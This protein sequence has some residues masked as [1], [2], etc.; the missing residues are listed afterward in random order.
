MRLVTLVHLRPD[1]AP[2]RIA[3]LEAVVAGLPDE[4]S[5]VRRV[6]LGKHIPG[7]VGAG[8]YTWDTLIG[9][10]DVRAVLDAPSLRALLEAGDLIERLDPVAFEPQK[11][12]IEEPDISKGL[13]RTL[14]VRLLP[15]TPPEVIAQF[16]RDILGMPEHI[17]G[18]RNWA[19]SRAD[20]SLCP[21]T[22]THV[23]EQ[24]YFD[25][26]GFDADYMMH[27]YHWGL[28]DGWFD[29][30][31]PQR[32]VD[33]AFAHCLCPAEATILGWK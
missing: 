10:G 31:C 18:I 7:Q 17:H 30:E 4:V 3:E 29:P 33:P 27:P 14:L 15:E 26:S 11:M 12:G 22:W 20:P 24:E 19:F 6:H 13:K 5:C 28:V 23:W 21:T 2:E 32:I 1:S 8:H 16:E 25:Q 9:D